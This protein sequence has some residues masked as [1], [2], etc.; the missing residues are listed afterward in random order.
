M[1]GSKKK[2]VHVSKGILG[3]L[4]DSCTLPEY[5]ILRKQID[6]L[7]LKG[8]NYERY[9][10][11]AMTQY[12]NYAVKKIILLTPRITWITRQNRLCTRVWIELLDV[13]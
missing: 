11:D 1:K 10:E 2:S 3:Q 7:I 6:P 12:K 8:S 4:Y 13:V 9:L 5:L